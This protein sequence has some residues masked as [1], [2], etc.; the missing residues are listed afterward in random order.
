M[1]AIL[2]AQPIGRS[3]SWRLLRDSPSALRASV[4]RRLP[5]ALMKS[6][7]SSMPDRPASAASPLQAGR[8]SA[9][10]EKQLL[11][12][13]ATTRSRSAVKPRR[14][15]ADDV[16]SL[17][18]ALAAVEQHERDDVAERGAAAADHHLRADPDML[19]DR[20]QAAH[21]HVVPDD[22]V[23]AQRRAVGE[24]DV[25]ADDAVVGD[26]AVRH[27]K[28][29][30]A[31]ARDA[32]AGNRAAVHGHGFADLAVGADLEPRRLALVAGRLRRGAERRRKERR[33]CA[34]R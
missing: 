13:G 6:R 2:G 4:N 7:I 15:Q 14:L 17:D 23:T 26:V 9:G 16:Q 22:R 32:A 5:P 8:K 11:I 20:G 29:A 33:R 30:V 34:D 3:V 24:D 27:E 28:S 19:V 10:T 21:E 31:D 25:V 1:S 18:H 12:E